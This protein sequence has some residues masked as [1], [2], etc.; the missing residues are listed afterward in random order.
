VRDW[1]CRQSL[2]ISLSC[3]AVW[4]ARRQRFWETRCLL[5]QSRKFLPSTLRRHVVPERRCRVFITKCL[6]SYPCMIILIP[7]CYFVKQYAQLGLIGYGTKSGSA[8]SLNV[9]FLDCFKHFQ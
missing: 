7:S 6:P 3:H 1:R 8:C 5:L 4:V 2:T 9:T